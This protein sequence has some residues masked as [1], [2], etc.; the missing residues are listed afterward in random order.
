[1]PKET[2]TN[3]ATSRKTAKPKPTAAERKAAQQERER[4]A[5]Q[6]RLAAQ[7]EF[8]AKRPA[9]WNEMWAKALRLHLVTCDM[10]DFRQK[11]SWWFDEF[12]VHP[13]EECFYL[14]DTGSLRICLKGLHPH[15]VGRVNAAL[16]NVYEWMAEFEA[17]KERKRQEELER[18]R[19]RDAALQKLT[20]EER[21][22]LGLR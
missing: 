22:L 17:E 20:P 11:F 16:D 2:T 13:R 8:D 7:A 18:E 3:S 12:R 6:A 19:K 21:K 4:K 9:L 1:M 15:D 14:E 10:E 5:E